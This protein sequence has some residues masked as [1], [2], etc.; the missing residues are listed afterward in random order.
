MKF[1]H[2]PFIY[3][4]IAINIVI[5]SEGAQW[6][7]E[8][9]RERENDYDSISIK[10]LLTKSIWNYFS[11]LKASRILNVFIGSSIWSTLWYIFI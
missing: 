1:P 9:E 7:W 11:W 4:Q 5:K 10:T 8:R 6:K 2:N 3:S